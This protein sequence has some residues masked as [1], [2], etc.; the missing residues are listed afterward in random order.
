MGLPQPNRAADFE[1]PIRGLLR[2]VNEHVT[3]LGGRHGS[4]LAE[5][6]YVCECT[7]VSCNVPV[8]L[9]P[10]RYEAIVK[11]PG[12]FVVAPGHIAQEE[13][14]VET[15]RAYAVVTRRSR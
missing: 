14:V 7:D 8:R 4:V 1:P 2:T 3:R 6:D 11:T 13:D 12:W 5:F 15:G 10:E 9:A